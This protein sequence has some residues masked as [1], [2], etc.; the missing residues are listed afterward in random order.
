MALC[1]CEGLTDV[2]S[3]KRNDH[4]PTASNYDDLSHQKR[5]TDEQKKKY[6]TIWKV[7]DKVRSSH[8]ITLDLVSG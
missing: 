6:L 7:Y 8:K 2:S 4:L 5:K 1:P 3:G